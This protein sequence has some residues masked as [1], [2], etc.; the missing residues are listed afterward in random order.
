M[1]VANLDRVWPR[2]RNSYR[3]EVRVSSERVGGTVEMSQSKGKR[4]G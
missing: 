3:L 2:Q 4:N 1:L